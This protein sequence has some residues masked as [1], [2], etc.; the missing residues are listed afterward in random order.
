MRSNDIAIVEKGGLFMSA[1]YDINYKS[2]LMHMP[3]R[4]SV[5]LPDPPEGVPP[6][7]F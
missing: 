7:Q 3:V 5:I 6:A 2:Q 1:V 4:L